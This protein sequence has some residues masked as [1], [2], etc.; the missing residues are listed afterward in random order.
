MRDLAIDHRLL[1]WPEFPIRYVPQPTWAREAAA[2]LYFLYYRSPAAFGR[3]SV[4]QYLVTPIEADMAAADR[5]ARLR[6]NN[7]AAIKLNHVV[8]HG[9]IGHHVQNWHA[10]RAESRIGR[11]AAVDGANRIAMHCGGTMAEGWA[12]YATDLVDEFGGLTPLESLS[13]IHTRIRMCSRAIV[14]IGF[15]TRQLTFEDAVALYQ[16]QAG[17]PED[18]AVYEATRNSMFPA[19]A[20]MYLVGTDRIHELRREL[21]A[22]HEGGFDLA[23]FHDRFLAYGSIP[24][25]L[26]AEAMREAQNVAH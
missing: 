21:A 8:H 23:E 16:E 26:I 24:V 18:A 13:E 4:H 10:F 17:M 15:H 6:S 9:G 20:L 25:P 2:D 7:D 11:V 12:C 22:R 5:K 1:T 19:T 3:P 14:D